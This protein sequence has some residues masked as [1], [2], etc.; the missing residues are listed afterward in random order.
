MTNKKATAKHRLGREV[1]GGMDGRLEAEAAVYGEELAGDEGGGGGEEEGGGGYVVC[2]SIALHGGLVGEVLEGGVDLALDD[3]AGGDAVDAD[4]G[5]PGLRHRLGE[6]MQ[7][8]LGGAVVGVGVPG[9]GAAQRAYVDDATLCGAEVGIGSFG[10]EEGGTGV[11][12]EHR[13]P[14]LDGDLFQY[15]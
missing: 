13:V 10:D 4:V 1:G 15:S 7:G 5:S 3:H 12:G 8:S 14:L 9:V 2:G 6:H 11:G